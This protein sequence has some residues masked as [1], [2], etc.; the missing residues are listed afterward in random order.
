MSHNENFWSSW[1]ERL[2]ALK[3]VPPILKI[4]WQSGPGVVT[5]GV[6]ARIVAALLPVALAYIPKLIIDILVHLLQ[7]AWASSDKALVACGCGVRPCRAER[8][9]HANDRLLRFLAC[10]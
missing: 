7:D 6:V 2:S 10:Q 1:Q 5:F 8:R 3:N 4:V 9:G